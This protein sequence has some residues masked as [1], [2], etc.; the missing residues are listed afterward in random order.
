MSNSREG[1]CDEYLLDSG[2]EFVAPLVSQWE[3][4]VSDAFC[5]EKG[6]EGERGIGEGV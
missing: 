3:P 1:T 6:E 5:L 4:C 2:D